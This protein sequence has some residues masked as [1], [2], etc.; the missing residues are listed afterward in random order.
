MRARKFQLLSPW[1]REARAFAV[2]VERAGRFLR[3]AR[4][5]LA[6]ARGVSLEEWR[7]L[8]VVSDTRDHRS[9]ARMARRLGISR[10]AVQFM[11]MRLQHRGW[12]ATAPGPV[13]RK[14]RCL[15]LT[16]TGARLFA[17]LDKT[18]DALRLEVSSEIPRETLSATTTLLDRLSS[19]LRRCE[20]LT[21]RRH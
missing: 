16:V 7:L 17:E 3:R 8:K 20:I 4:R 13:N 5:G 2:A 21:R 15:L 1:R 11:S 12:L 14:N 19:R 10:Q 18:M 6:K 9:M